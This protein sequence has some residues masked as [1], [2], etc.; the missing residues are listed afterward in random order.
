MNGQSHKI[1]IT[2][3]PTLNFSI[4]HVSLE[5]L[6]NA[7]HTNELK[8]TSRPYL[9]IDMAQTGLGSNACGPDTLKKYRLETKPYSFS[10]YLLPEA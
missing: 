8:W 9:Y 3:K 2:G 1:Q 10:F 5:N 7:K 4:H 6:T